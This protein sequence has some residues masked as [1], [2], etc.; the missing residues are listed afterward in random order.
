[1]GKFKIDEQL[2]DNNY[3]MIYDDFV[4]FIQTYICIVCLLQIDQNN[5]LLI[6]KLAFIEKFNTHFCCLFDDIALRVFYIYNYAFI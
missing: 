1:M 2:Q 4:Y 6:H 3:D 5:D